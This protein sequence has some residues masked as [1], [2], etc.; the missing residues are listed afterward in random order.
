MTFLGVFALRAYLV[1]HQVYFI[2]YPKHVVVLI[3]GK[4][5]T[6][7]SEANLKSTKRP[8]EA[9]VSVKNTTPT[10]SDKEKGKTI[11][12]KMDTDVVENAESTVRVESTT[13]NAV[14]LPRFVG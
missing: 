10:A 6:K 14:L 8:K 11:A 1:L 13:G 7:K 2:L 4:Q 9:D 3:K 5:R 12:V